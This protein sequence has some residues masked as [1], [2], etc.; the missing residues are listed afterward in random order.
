[1]EVEFGINK[2]SM[3]FHRVG[4]VYRRLANFIDKYI[5]F[6]REGYNFSY[7]NNNNNNSLYF[8]C[9]QSFHIPVAD[10]NTKD[11]KLRLP[12][13]SSSQSLDLHSSFLGKYIITFHLSL[14]LF[15]HLHPQSFCCVIAL[16]I[17][18]DVIWCACFFYMH[19]WPCFIFPW[20]LLSISRFWRI[21][22]FRLRTL[23]ATRTNGRTNCI[24]CSSAHISSALSKVQYPLPLIHLSLPVGPT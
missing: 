3:V 6:P 5:C 1:M 4:P 19:F 23:S 2:H 18:Y 12:F 17:H 20:I 13:P 8:L 7:N 14:D 10:L 22:S 9:R 15:W 11:V 24:C 21:S 16:R